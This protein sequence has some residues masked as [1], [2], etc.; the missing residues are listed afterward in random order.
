[1][2]EVDSYQSTNR[3]FSQDYALAQRRQEIENL[4]YNKETKDEYKDY[5][6]RCPNCG[7]HVR[8]RNGFRSKVVVW[9]E[10][11]V[12]NFCGPKCW[13]FWKS[14]P[15]WNVKELVNLTFPTALLWYKQHQP[16]KPGED[17]MLYE[18]KKREEWRQWCK[19]K[20]LVK[21]DD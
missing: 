1:M 9:Y 16:I 8:L 4:R 12:R 14:F 2:M 20:L 15:A 3:I 13:L 5:G 18:R 7:V 19:E 21:S 17:K 10:C 11:P 6:N